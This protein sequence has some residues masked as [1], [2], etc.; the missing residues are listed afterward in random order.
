MS[1]CNPILPLVLATL[2]C[3]STPRAENRATL[4]EASGLESVT[5]LARG[6]E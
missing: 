3:Q 5:I 4:R 1:R 2:S 6:M